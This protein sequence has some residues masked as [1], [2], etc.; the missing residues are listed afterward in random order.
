VSKTIDVVVEIPRGSR[1][2]YEFD[3]ALG[4]LRLDRVL[5][6]SVHYPTDYGF[7]PNTLMG[8]GDPLDVVL[9]VEEPSVPNSV[10]AVRP[11]GL[12]DMTEEDGPD[13]KVLAVPAGDPRFASISGLDDLAPHW[14]L[15]IEHFFRTYKAL[16]DRQIPVVKGWRDANAAWATIHEGQQGYGEGQSRSNLSSSRAG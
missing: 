3:A 4:R 2:K 15:E 10:Q 11:I 13:A 1:S 9:V 16:E 6:A 14:L 8:D 7:I 5:H 12:L